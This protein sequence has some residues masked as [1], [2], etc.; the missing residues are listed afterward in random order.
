M[1]GRRC[2][3]FSSSRESGARIH[4]RF[5]VAKPFE[6]LNGR[7][8]AFDGNRIAVC[9]AYEYHGHSGNWFRTYGNENWEF[10]DRDL[11]RVRHAS[12]NDLAI[13][14]SD[15]KY[16]WLLGR[17]PDQYPEFSDLGF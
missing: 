6:L 7:Q 2:L 11:M 15:R 16:H 8:G 10:D 9:F 3:E 14:E 12:I 4:V 1:S 5:A 17:Q 13:Q